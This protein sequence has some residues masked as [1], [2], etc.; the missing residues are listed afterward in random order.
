LTPNHMDAMSHMGVARDVCAWLTHHEGKTF[1]VKTPWPQNF[2]PDREDKPMEVLI[3]N[4]RACGRYSGISLAGVRIMASPLWMQQRRR[5]IGLR[6]INNIVDITNYVLHETGQPLHAFDAQRIE[7]GRIVVGNL[8]EGS[9]FTTLD[10]KER[11]MSAED[12][13][14][15]DA[16][17]ALA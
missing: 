13:M 16:R 5:A 14:I 6:P 7:G 15:C 9:H 10:G 1:R 12:L 3:E 2:K 11:T 17:K 4:A 8:P